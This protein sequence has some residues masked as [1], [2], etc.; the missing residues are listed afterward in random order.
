MFLVFCFKLRAA[1]FEVVYCLVKL[2]YLC[3]QRVCVIFVLLCLPIEITLLLLDIIC[4]LVKLLLQ[5]SITSPQ[6]AAL[7]FPLLQFYVEPFYLLLEL[8]NLACVGLHLSSVHDCVVLRN[9]RL[10]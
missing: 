7:R 5:M 3:V 1:L 4:P 8:K 2:R 6:L 9:Y 10:L